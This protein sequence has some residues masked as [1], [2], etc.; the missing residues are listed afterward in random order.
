MTYQKKKHSY[1]FCRNASLITQTDF[2]PPHT[3]TQWTSSSPPVLLFQYPYPHKEHPD[4]NNNLSAA[5][6]HNCATSPDRSV[7]TQNSFI[8][9]VQKLSTHH[10]SHPERLYHPDRLFHQESSLQPVFP[11]ISADNVSMDVRHIPD[12]T[13]LR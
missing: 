7:S 5:Y 6:L 2:D 4:W 13:H 1:F 12:H 10:P 11:H 3:H 9:T 8:Q